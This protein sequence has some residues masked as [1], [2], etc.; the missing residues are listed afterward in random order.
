MGLDDTCA[1]SKC[2]TIQMA[3]SSEV[4][5]TN[6]DYT[7][8][9]KGGASEGVS[10]S[11]S[12]FSK[13]FS[14]SSFFTYWRT[15]FTLCFGIFVWWW[16]LHFV[17]NLHCQ[18]V[19]LWHGGSRSSLAFLSGGASG[20]VAMSSWQTLPNFSIILWSSLC[21]LFS[22]T[23]YNFNSTGSLYTLHN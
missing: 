18:I 20:L 1:H 9:K 12:S 2:L 8:K 6:L 10:S 13:A 16:L 21:F 11:L 23:R 22:H 17:G 15:F 19:K 4:M 3:H 5:S 7:S 14:G